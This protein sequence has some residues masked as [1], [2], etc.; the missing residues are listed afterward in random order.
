MSMVKPIFSSPT[1]IHYFSIRDVKWKRVDGKREGKELGM[2]VFGCVDVIIIF[3]LLCQVKLLLRTC[4]L[5]YQRTAFKCCLI[6][7]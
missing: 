7:V 1:K 6:L 2:C 5:R 3:L 4:Q